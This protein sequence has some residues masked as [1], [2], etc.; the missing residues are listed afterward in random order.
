MESLSREQF[1][2]GKFAPRRS[3]DVVAG[4]QTRPDVDLP[5]T[6]STPYLTPDISAL[7]FTMMR[8]YGIRVQ[9]ADS[10]MVAAGD[11]R[12]AGD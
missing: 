2:S 4:M 11:I 10:M 1:S 7:R 8:I 3:V 5:A 9:Q 12:G 6:P